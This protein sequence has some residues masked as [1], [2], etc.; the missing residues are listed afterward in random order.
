MLDHF[1]LSII[2]QG[3]AQGSRHMPEFLRE[4]LA[5]TPRIRPVHPGQQDQACRPFHQGP[6]G[7]PLANASSRTATAKD[8][9]VCAAAAVDVRGLRPA[10]V[11]CRRDRGGL[12]VVLRPNSRLTVL[13]A[14]PNPFA[15]VRNDWLWVR[16]RLNVSRSVSLKCV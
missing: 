2:G 5:G 14:R 4:A 3:V 9:G 1:F 10:S 8:P 15:I 16:P 13:G 12:A 6:D 11:P 7:R